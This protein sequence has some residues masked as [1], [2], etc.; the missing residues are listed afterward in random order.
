[1]KTVSTDKEE[2][3]QGKVGKSSLFKQKA[4]NRAEQKQ[5]NKHH[6]DT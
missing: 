5:K 4:S 3:H 6:V 1:M 2:S